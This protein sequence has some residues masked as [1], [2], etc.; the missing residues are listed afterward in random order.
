MKKLFL[1]LWLVLILVFSLAA[2]DTGKTGDNVLI[3]PDHTHS[4]GEWETTKEASCLGT[5]TKTRYCACGEK[6]SETIPT[7]GHSF[8]EWVVVEEATA[9]EDG[10]EE[11][12]CACGEKET[13]VLPAEPGEPP[14]THVFDQKVTTEAYLKS[15]ATATEPAYYYYSCVCGVGGTETFIHGDALENTLELIYAPTPDYSFY[16]VTGVTGRGAVLEV[17]YLH[18]GLRVVGIAEGAFQ[19]NTSIRKIIL[20]NTIESIG[21]DAFRGC[22]ALVEINL[23]EESVSSI[24]TYAFADCA[25][26]V[27]IT[28][29]SK[30]EALPEGIFQGCTSLTQITLQD[31][32]KTIGNLAFDGCTALPT[33]TIPNTVT[34]L[35][36]MTFRH[37]EALTSV[38]LSTGL[39]AIGNA[40]FQYCKR[41]ASVELHSKITVI[42]NSAFSYCYGLKELRILGAITSWGNSAFYECTGLESFYIETTSK[43]SVSAQNYIFYNAGTAGKG[44]TIFYKCD[45][46]YPNLLFTPNDNQNLPKI[47]ARK[48][49]HNYSTAWTTD[50]VDHWHKCLNSGCSSV[51]DTTAHDFGEWIVDKAATCQK[52]GTRHH[53]CT[54][55]NKSV[56]ET[57]PVDTNAHNYATT[58]TSDATHHWYACLNAGCT[59]VSGKSAHNVVDARC[60]GC[61]DMKYTRDGSYIYFGEYPQTVKADNVTITSTT[62]S[63]GYYLG[64]DGFYYAKSTC[65]RTLRDYTLSNGGSVTKGT[66]YYFKVEPIRW[67]ILSES[68]GNALILCDIIIDYREFNATDDNNYKNSDIRKWLNGEFLSNTFN[69]LQQGLINCVEVDNSFATYDWVYSGMTAQENTFDKVFL[70]SFA[71]ATNASYGFNQDTLLRQPS[72]YSLIKGSVGIWQLRTPIKQVQINTY[73]WYDHVAVV[74]QWGFV[75]TAHGSHVGSESGIVPALQIRLK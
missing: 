65:S 69:G 46:T 22:T 10:L 48:A 5:G 13:H 62:D 59:T 11:R 45:I 53:V 58:W 25:S 2:C 7:L 38:K 31:G 26:L 33:I 3:D 42:G 68:D 19:N 47:A 71:D 56:S 52:T 16:M 61:G 12:V 6:E 66:T 21:A 4:Y 44:L 75:N 28:I 8:G 17:P 39:T 14:H 67:R 57:I 29:P 20:P 1:T 54:I 15:E 73:I 40:T 49:V 35:G 55:C 30:I 63:R 41:L 24:G 74:D 64:S 9:T 60:A 70:L 36:N 37:A 72:D 27:N 43:A 51:S 32:L 34:S 23:P 50:N 18:D